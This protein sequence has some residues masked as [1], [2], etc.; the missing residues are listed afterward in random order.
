LNG[1]KKNIIV[2][3]LNL[4]FIQRTDRKSLN[5]I[6]NFFWAVGK[7]YIFKNTFQF[8]N[9]LTWCFR[10]FLTIFKPSTHGTFLNLLFVDQCDCVGRIR[11]QCIIASAIS[12]TNINANNNICLKLAMPWTQGGTNRYRGRDGRGQKK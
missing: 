9:F 7:V 10:N 2:L 12:D 8:V 5:T 4:I 11:I 3:I 1:I 6:D